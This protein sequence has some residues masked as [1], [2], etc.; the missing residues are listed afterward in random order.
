MPALPLDAYALC[1]HCLAPAPADDPAEA[2]LV[3]KLEDE[4][5]AAAPFTDGSILLQV[6]FRPTPQINSG[7]SLLLQGGERATGLLERVLLHAGRCPHNGCRHAGEVLPPANHRLQLRLAAVRSLG[8]PAH[9][10]AKPS[11]SRWTAVLLARP[12]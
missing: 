5:D 3:P 7:L 9:C 1:A 11:Y 6:I 4:P 10:G 2:L 12:L 8:N